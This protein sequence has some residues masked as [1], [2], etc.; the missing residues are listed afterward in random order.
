MDKISLAIQGF[1]NATFTPNDV[2]VISGIKEVM[3]FVG[4]KDIFPE[5][6]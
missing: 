5:F 6:D 3:K 4:E 1:L 2:R